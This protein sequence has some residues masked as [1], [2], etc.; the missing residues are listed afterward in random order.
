[1][2]IDHEGLLKE[3]EHVARPGERK[4]F[5]EDVRTC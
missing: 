1:M 4:H 3:L 5:D 2:P